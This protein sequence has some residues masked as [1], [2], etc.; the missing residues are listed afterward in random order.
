MSLELQP[1]LVSSLM[2]KDKWLKDTFEHL[3]KPRNAI[4]LYLIVNFSPL[5][6]IAVDI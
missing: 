5:N 4:A 1:N 2:L 6:G 3:F